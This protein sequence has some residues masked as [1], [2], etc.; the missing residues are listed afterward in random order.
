MAQAQQVEKAKLSTDLK[1]ERGLEPAAGFEKTKGL[2]T[3]TP[4]SR[5]TS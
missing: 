1:I 3:A 5:R 2:A 4:K